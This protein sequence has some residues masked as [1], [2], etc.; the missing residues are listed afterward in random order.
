MAEML[1]KIAEIRRMLD[2]VSSRA[3]LE[4]DGGIGLSNVAEVVSAGANVL[5]AGTSVF[6]NPGGAAEAVEKF[7]EAQKILNASRVSA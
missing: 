5:V 1:P 2:A 7:H 3:H 4:V 6:R